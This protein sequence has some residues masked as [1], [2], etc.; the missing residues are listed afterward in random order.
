M[1][2]YGNWALVG[3]TDHTNS[4]GEIVASKAGGAWVQ[5][6]G[7]G[8]VYN[9]SELQSLASVDSTSAAFLV[10]NLRPLPPVGGP[11]QDASGTLTYDAFTQRCSGRWNIY[12]G[13]DSPPPYIVTASIS[14]TTLAQAV[15][16]DVTPTQNTTTV[17]LY[18]P[19]GPLLSQSTIQVGSTGGVGYWNPNA[20]TG[21]YSIGVAGTHVST[22]DLSCGTQ[23]TSTHT[24]VDTTW[25]ATLAW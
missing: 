16:I 15:T 25:N 19:G 6:R 2:I 9:A 8:G 3:W 18:A 7:T 22:L 20:P 14:P 24:Y 5:V 12:T 21:V 4:A 17:S 23:P 10:A 13:D 1:A 11:T